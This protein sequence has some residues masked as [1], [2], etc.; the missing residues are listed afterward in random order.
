MTSSRLKPF[1]MRMEYFTDFQFI[2]FKP[3]DRILNIHNTISN[4]L[5]FQPMLEIQEHGITYLR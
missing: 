5:G 3:R 1:I 4:Y 2:L